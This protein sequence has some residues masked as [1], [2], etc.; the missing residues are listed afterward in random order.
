MRVHRL[1][2]AITDVQTIAEGRGVDN[3]EEMNAVHGAVAE[4]EG[5]REGRG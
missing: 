3:L 5:G 2:T 4:D 1:L